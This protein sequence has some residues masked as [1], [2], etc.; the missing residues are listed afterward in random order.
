M[1]IVDIDEIEDKLHGE[2]GDAFRSAA[3]KSTVIVERREG[4]IRRLFGFVS[5]R[6]V[7][8]RI[9]KSREGDREIFKIELLK[10]R[11]GV[12]GKRLKAEMLTECFP[13]GDDYFWW[14][15]DEESA[16]KRLAEVCIR[17]EINSPGSKFYVL[18]MG[19]MI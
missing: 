8:A 17:Y 3:K 18:Y 16:I 19:S 12:F 7:D 6:T 2:D 1:R 10:E 9:V 11:D 15:E 4:F 14:A 5:S 13:G